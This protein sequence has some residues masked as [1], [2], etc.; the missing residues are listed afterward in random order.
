MVAEPARRAV[1]DSHDLLD[2]AR[3]EFLRDPY[4]TYRAL[5]EAGP[6]HRVSNGPL[7]F[8]VLTRH[9][10]VLALLR[11]PRVT[12]DRMPGLQVDPNAPPVDPATLNPFART[13]RTLARVMLFR[14][15]PDHTRLRGLANKAFTPRMVEQL[16]PRIAAL[17][18]ELL[19]PLADGAPFDVVRELAE[20]LPILVIAELLGLPVEDRKQ[21]K[22]WSDDLAVLL[23]GSIAMQ[24]LGR[25]IQ[26]AI[27]VFDYLRGHLEERRRSPR[28]DLLSAM[29]AARERDENLNDDEILATALLV[30]GAGHETTTNLIGNATLALLRNPGE[31]A[32][33]RAEPALLLGAVEE[34]LRYD[35][36]VQGTARA[37]RE[38]IEIH[39]TTIPARREILLPIGCANRDPAVFADPER[40]DVA[41]ADVRHVSFGYGIHFCLGAGLARL[42]A[43]RAIG[44]LLEH[45]PGLAPAVD[46]AELAWRPGWLL[47]GLTALPVRR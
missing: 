43:Q 39:G 8:W 1:P 13:L 24:H 29:L 21:L 40:L 37:T 25:G 7:R 18:G 41:R 14:D 10:D 30:M 47:R 4:P 32:R 31:L 2:F 44:G 9:A 46:E 45:A 6:L 27:A 28:E 38:P 26:S 3:P 5:R 33:L 15:P 20:P 17:V 19:A 16:R 23:D 36:P 12:V 34:F 22:E 42:E 11:D 35:A